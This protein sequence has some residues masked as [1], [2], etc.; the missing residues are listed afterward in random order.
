MSPPAV[1]S[2]EA[3]GSL[4]GTGEK[5]GRGIAPR[6]RRG[7]GLARQADLLRYIQGHI[8][9]KG[10]TP[11]FKEMS[12]GIGV[13][14]RTTLWGLLLELRRRGSIRKLNTSPPAF[15]VL[16][17]IAIPR[18]PDGAPLYFIP[19]G[20]LPGGAIINPFHTADIRQGE[21]KNHG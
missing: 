17:P 12:A 8:E 7:L 20:H 3:L 15:E 13:R 19:A 5:S 9:A 11:T 14:S 16:K 1:P 18:G 21:P 2:K 4:P 10:F 6:G